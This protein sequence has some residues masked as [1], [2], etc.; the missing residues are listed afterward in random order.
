M[1]RQLHVFCDASSEA[2]AAAVYWRLEEEDGTVRVI[3]VAAKA[4]VAPLRAQT[5]PRMELQAA[6]LGARLASAITTEHREKPSKTIYWS[7]SKTTLQWI[8]ND[9]AKHTPFVAHRVTEI[10]ELTNPCDWRWIPT[11]Q[12]VAD[13][14]TRPSREI[15][16]ASDRWFTGPSFLRLSEEHWPEEVH[17]PEE[18]PEEAYVQHVRANIKDALPDIMRFSKYE[19]LIRATAYV[20]LFIDACRKRTRT[21]KVRHLRQAEKLWIKRSQEDAYPEDLDQMKKTGTISKS[22][23]GVCEHANRHTWKTAMAL[24]DEFW[25]RWIAEYLPTLTPRGGSNSNSRNVQE[26]DLVVVVDSNLPRNVWPRGEVVKTYP[27]PDGNVRCVDVRT[28]GGTF[29]RPVRKLAVLPIQEGSEDF[30]GGRML[31]TASSKP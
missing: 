30:A 13:D 4:R 10:A 18:V 26:G 28:K 17:N 1:D 9:N 23:T 29:K 7:D 25:R 3:L 16:D 20:L 31:R 19:R 22:I 21:L 8:R 11:D 14:A 6:L 5:I 15:K 12:N 24:A 27:G 2:F